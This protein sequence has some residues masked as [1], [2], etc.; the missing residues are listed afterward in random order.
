MDAVKDLVYQVRRALT[1]KGF[2]FAVCLMLYSLF[3]VHTD[4]TVFFTNPLVYFR[5]NINFYY[6]FIVSFWMGLSQYVIP[7]AAILTFGMFLCEDRHSGFQNLSEYRLSRGRYLIHRS[8]AAMLSAMLATLIACVLFT[9]FLLLVCTTEGG[10]R[11]AWLLNR[12]DSAFGWLATPAHF[13]F[14]ILAQYARLTVSS[15]LWALVAVSFSMLWA[16]KAFVLIGTFGFSILLDVVLGRHLGEEYA[17]AVLQTPDLNTLTPL[18]TLFGRQVLYLGIAVLLCWLMIV[19][20]SSRA[21]LRWKQSCSL[22][23]AMWRSKRS[24]RSEWNLPSAVRGGFF[25]A[26]LT[27]FRSF[28]SPATLLPAVAIPMLVTLCKPIFHNP[29]RSVGDMW[30]SIFGGFGWFEPMVNF[31][32][33]G[34]WVLLLL[35]PMMG[36]ALILEREFGTRVYATLFRFRSRS[37]W[38]LCK[39]LALSLYTILICLIMFASVALLA[40]L[41][42]SREWGVLMEDADGFLSPT[43]FI[44]LQCFVIFAEQVLMLCLFQAFVHLATGRMQL[45]VIAYVLPYIACL[46][47]F[48]VFDRT[49]N[50]YVPYNWGMLLRSNLFY[51]GNTV[52][53]DVDFSSIATQIPMAFWGQLG[54]SA[55][56]IGLGLGYARVFNFAQREVK[57]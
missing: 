15:G 50:I 39:C 51:L 20:R 38:W 24:K 46:I 8:L 53:E 31:T 33:I 36:V 18:W 9:V 32:P 11:E 6:H 49:I 45:G 52:V 14:F 12:K 10:E 7:L 47:A 34:L 5:E 43:Y 29:Y 35:P 37:R 55:L 22:R 25:S 13:P 54:I 3:F 56:F 27:D 2:F 28:I 30:L 23:F 16:N 48:S 40:L 41:S 19:L 1:G 4:T 21:C 42:G 57:E 17:I 44:L 26:V